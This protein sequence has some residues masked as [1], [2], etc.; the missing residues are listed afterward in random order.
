MLLDGV[1]EY[2]LNE[3]P[4][5]DSEWK[6]INIPNNWYLEGI[7]HSGEVYFREK[8]KSKPYLD[9]EYIIKFYGVDYLCDVWL[10]DVY[11]GH[12]EG[13]FQPFEFLITPY[14]RKENIL[15]VKVNSPR[16]NERPLKKK[17]I[18]GVLSDHD[19]RPRFQSPI[20]GEEH[21]T[22]GIWNSIEVMEINRIRIKGSKIYS[23]LLPSGEATITINCQ[24]ENYQEPQKAMI[25]YSVQGYN[26][27]TESICFSKE[28]FLPRGDDKIYKVI[29]IKKPCLWWTWDLGRPNLYKVEIEVETEK[30]KTKLTQ[31]FGI[32]KIEIDKDW[33]W[34][35]NH[36]HIFPRGTNIIPTQWLAEYTREKI[37][38]DIRLLKGANVNAV[39]VHGHITRE[40]FYSQC[41][42]E[43]ILVWQDF[44][45][46]WRYYEDSDK[47]IS[48]A[49]SQ[50]EDM[51]ELLYN[52]PCI[53]V[54]C[55]HNEPG[56]TDREK[57]DFVLYQKVSSL[58]STRYVNI[59]SDEYFHP[60]PGWYYGYYREFSGL[61]G[62]PFINEFGA[63]ALPSLKTLKEIFPPSELWPPKWGK[64]FYHNFQYDQ[65]F[66]VAKIDK[67]R[68][69]DE[70]ISNSQEYQAK[71]LKYAIEHYRIAKFKEITGIFQFM[72]VDCWPSITWS[73]V[74]YKRVPKKGYYALKQAYQPV[75]PVLKIIRETLMEG[76]VELKLPLYVVND[77]FYRYEKASI[78]VIIERECRLCFQFEEKVDIQSNCSQ[79]VYIPSSSDSETITLIP[80]KYIIK[81]ILKDGKKF[82]GINQ[83]FVEVVPA[84]FKNSSSS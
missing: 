53:S 2:S 29:S 15:L 46:Q 82:I 83:Y 60:Y 36:K 44:A 34:Y 79:L 70:F 62:K 56:D 33:N 57:L 59:S 12:H 16:E 32:R 23:F 63:Q 69:I 3:L 75:L 17:L 28:V 41:D 81:L 7:E 40:E 18:K 30:G 22:G 9:K 5:D 13:Y 61:P 64:W 14:L 54:W 48:N 73:V 38:K 4:K 45:L 58:D 55:C 21:N 74:D 42:K 78:Q 35:L 27:S 77:T 43:G 19:C 25:K 80:G 47:F 20:Y 49:S 68:D 50:I 52:H 76:K 10:N 26:F 71:L 84:E 1:W 66:N 8:F 72:F 37:N 11:L 24:I 6:K 65:T 31:I 51:V 67:G 39:R